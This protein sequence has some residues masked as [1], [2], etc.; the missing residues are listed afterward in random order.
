MHPLAQR[1]ADLGGQQLLVVGGGA[2]TLPAEALIGLHD[3]AV[4]APRARWLIAVVEGA[5]GVLGVDGWPRLWRDALARPYLHDPARRLPAR[6]QAARLG[7][8]MARL[9]LEDRE[10]VDAVGRLAEVVAATGDVESA[11]ARL[12]VL[13]AAVGLPWEEGVTVALALGPTL[14]TF[15]AVATALARHG[16][17]DLVAAVAA[18]NAAL[19]AAGTGSRHAFASVR[20]VAACVRRARSSAI[21][22]ART[23]STPT[24]F[25]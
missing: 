4:D 14:D 5:L 3:E 13:R 16:D 11:L 2:V 18:L 6:A 10:D 19:G 20:R 15:T 25:S 1:R 22:S 21:T 9:L 7:Q 12:A 23:R 8:V 17:E 24:A